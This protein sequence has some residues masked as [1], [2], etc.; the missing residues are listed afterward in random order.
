MDLLKENKKKQIS[1]GS[2]MIKKAENLLQQQ[3]SES[4]MT[5]NKLMLFKYI[6]RMQTPAF[7]QTQTIPGPLELNEFFA[8]IGR[9]IDT[10]YK[11][12]S[13]LVLSRACKKLIFLFCTIPT[14]IFNFFSTFIKDSNSKREDGIP[15]NLVKFFSRLNSENLV[16]LIK[17]WMVEAY[18]LKSLRFARVVLLFKSGDRQDP[19]NYRTNSVLPSLRK[20]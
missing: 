12:S 1:K 19:S 5:Q 17:R 6:G 16:V 20:F 13:D 18:F 8:P 14:K 3:Q 15:N 7:S 11:L 2:K 9:E 10:K 4:L